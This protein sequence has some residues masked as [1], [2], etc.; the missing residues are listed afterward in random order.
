MHRTRISTVHFFIRRFLRIRFFASISNLK[1]H[2]FESA[3]PETWDEFLRGNFKVSTSN[4]VP[5]TR[6]GVDHAMEHLNKATKGQG[7]ISGITSTPQ[8]LL[9]FCLT[10]PELARLSDETAHL[11]MAS[12]GNTAQQHHCLSKG[13]VARQEK[14]I[15]KLKAVLAQCHLFSPPSDDAAINSQMFKLMSKEI[16][17]E[18]V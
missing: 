4:N 15:T 16:F 3:N 5:F 13:K 17:Q 11:L 9:K 12:E 10:G 18:E 8:T 2:K 14:A 7:G 1:E 6:I